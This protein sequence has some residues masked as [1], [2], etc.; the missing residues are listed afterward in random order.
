[1]TMAGGVSD[2][3]A[4]RH[5]GRTATATPGQLPSPAWKRAGLTLEDRMSRGKTARKEAPRSSHGRWEPT[6]NRPDPVALLQQQ[7]EGRLPELVPI[8]YGRML[9]S[10][11]TFYRAPR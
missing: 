5:P 1:M 11:G 3:G 10:P 7:A 4:V 9:V 2:S 8:R 6:A